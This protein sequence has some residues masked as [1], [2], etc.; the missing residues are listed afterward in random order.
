[1]DLG[2]RGRHALVCGGSK[3]LGHA[4]AE[5]L[6]L[7]GVAVTLV[8]RSAETLKRAADDIAERY[9]VSANFVAADV[10]TPAGRAEVLAACPDPDILVT[11]PG[12]RQ[13]PADFRG[14]SRYDWDH[15]FEAHCFSSLELIQKIVPGMCDRKFG[16]VVNISVSN[17]KFPQVNF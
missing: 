14:L 4:A 10:T 3:G 11:N 1:M 2:I 7:E 8:A 16:R 13:T 5:A 9:G 17:I 6:A 15:W 12:V